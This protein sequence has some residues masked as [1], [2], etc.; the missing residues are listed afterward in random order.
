MLSSS[1]PEPSQ[2][3]H[4]AVVS[5]SRTSDADG[6]HQA[7]GGLPEDDLRLRGGK[8]I[9]RRDGVLGVAAGERQRVLDRAAGP[10]ELAG[11][12]DVDTL[13][14]CAE[15]GAQLGVAALEGAD[16]RQGVDA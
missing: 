14:G 6:V 7:D 5:R 9:K 13:E 11:P 1:W 12:L 10:N 2:P 15:Q 8:D 4:S 3:D 16:D